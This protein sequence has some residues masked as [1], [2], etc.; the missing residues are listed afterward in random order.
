MLQSFNSVMENNL[1][2]G[3]E[4]EL[5]K[6]IIGWLKESRLEI[7]DVIKLILSLNIFC[8]YGILL[9]IYK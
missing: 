3:K 9:Y 4:G 7:E 2:E 6:N 8:H 1:N 5:S